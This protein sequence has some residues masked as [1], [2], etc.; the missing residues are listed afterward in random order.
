MI[1]RLER[2]VPNDVYDY[3]SLYRQEQLNL[4]YTWEGSEQ[5]ASSSRSN[6]WYFGEE[7]EEE[8]SK[9]DFLREIFDPSHYKFMIRLYENKNSKF[10]ST[11]GYIDLELVRN[12]TYRII[13]WAMS[14]RQYKNA[15]WKALLKEK[16]PHCK[17]FSVYMCGDKPTIEWLE[18]LGF[19]KLKTAEYGI[20]TKEPII[21]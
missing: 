8:F 10:C 5:R 14:S 3:M 20:Y 4:V 16:L 18:E 19:K 17:K 6:D 9:D 11:I 13:D 7:N 15:A 12:K 1:I 21:D 2:A